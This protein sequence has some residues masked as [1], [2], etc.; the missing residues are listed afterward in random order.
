MVHIYIY[1]YTHNTMPCKQCVQ[2]MIYKNVIMVKEK[3]SQASD[4]EPRLSLPQC[5]IVARKQMTS[6]G[7]KFLDLG[8]QQES[9]GKQKVSRTDAQHSQVWPAEACHAGSPSFLLF[10]LIKR[11]SWKPCVGDNSAGEAW[12]QNYNAEEG[13]NDELLNLPPAM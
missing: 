8:E 11:Q 2:K 13:H 9:S 6:Q 4:K 3:D 12:F 1:I 10:S 7:L 5:I